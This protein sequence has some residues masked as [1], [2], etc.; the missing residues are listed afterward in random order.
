MN[1]ALAAA[2]ITLVAALSANA[3]LILNGSNELPLLVSG[4][5]PNWT[6]VVGTTWTQR[7]DQSDPGVSPAAFDGTYYFFAGAVADATLRQDVDVSGLASSIDAG[8]MTFDFTGYV[9]TF[10][11]V[12]GLDTSRISLSFLAANGSF[13]GTFFDS[14]EIASVTW[15]RVSHSSLAVPL[16]RKVRVDL[17]SH[18]NWATN[19]DGYFD[20]LSLTPI[21]IPEPGTAMLTLF[22]AVAA[23]S[24]RRRVSR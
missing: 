18:R 16:T 1:R 23:V 22:A 15:Q 2:A 10:F 21:P 20:A 9:H 19:N 24:R 17:L 8:L 4:E 12:N 14:G 3:N 13:L 11:S 5:I 7:S 6:E